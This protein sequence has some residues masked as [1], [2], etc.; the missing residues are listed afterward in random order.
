M[1]YPFQ[2]IPTLV[3]YEGWHKSNASY[4][5]P[6]QKRL[7]TVKWH[8]HL[9]YILYKAGNIFSYKVSFITNV[10]F[11]ISVWDAVC[12]SFKTFWWS[13]G[14]FHS[15]HFSLTSTK[16]HSRMH[17]SGGQNDGSS[18][19]LNWDCREDEVEQIQGAGFCHDYCLLGQRRNF[20]SVIREQKCHNRFKA[21]CADIKKLQH[22]IQRVQPNRK[23]DQVVILPTVDI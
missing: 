1:T 3:T 12:R 22:W 13:T 21:I 20:V 5:F 4:S 7:S 10:P 2:H 14:A 8:L 16:R 19:V 11:S 6:P 23:M 17:P 9:E 18:R 15:C